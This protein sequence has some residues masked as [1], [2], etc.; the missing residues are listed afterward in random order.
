MFG[1]FMCIEWKRLCLGMFSCKKSVNSLELALFVF[2]NS[3]ILII[4]KESSLDGRKQVR[5]CSALCR[6][7]HQNCEPGILRMRII[8]DFHW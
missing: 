6:S 7:V 1:H 8:P 5:H 2:I 4:R 3:I